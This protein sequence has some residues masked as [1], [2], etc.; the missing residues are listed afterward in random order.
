LNSGDAVIG[1]GYALVHLNRFH[2]S[3]LQIAT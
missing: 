1:I 2:A 3:W